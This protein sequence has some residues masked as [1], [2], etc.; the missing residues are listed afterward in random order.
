VLLLCTR[1][2]KYVDGYRREVT[3]S[4]KGKKGEKYKNTKSFASFALFAL[5]ASIGSPSYPSMN[6]WRRVF[7]LFELRR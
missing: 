1:R 7:S 3:G 6:F 4:K 2:Q 5:F